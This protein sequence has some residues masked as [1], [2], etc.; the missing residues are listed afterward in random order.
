MFRSW[1]AST[2]ATVYVVVAALIIR[3]EVRNTGGGFINLRAFGTNAVT[4]PSQLIL[5]PVFRAL[6]VARIDI[7]DPGP[8]GWVQLTVH[9]VVTAALVYAVGWGIEWLARRGLSALAAAPR[10]GR[11]V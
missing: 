5:G 11:S 4:A 9:V 3:W 6:G 1:L 10:A 8:S 2:L 7:D